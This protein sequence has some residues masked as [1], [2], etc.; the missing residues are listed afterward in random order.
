MVEGRLDEDDDQEESLHRGRLQAQG[1][2]TERS[3]AWVQRKPPNESQM[4]R[5]CE[6]LE[7]QLT[8]IEARDRVEPLQRLRNY[9]RNAA[10]RGGVNAPL[11]KSFLK[12]GSPDIR[13][14]LEVIK[15]MAC[16]PDGAGS[17]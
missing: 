11:K 8:P 5:N 13:V 3:E 9:I 17:E 10:R 4:L 7:Q 12:R 14:D 15:G 1:G 6:L 2:G 16:V